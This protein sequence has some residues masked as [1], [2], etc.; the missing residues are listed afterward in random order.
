[1][2]RLDKL[3]NERAEVTQAMDA[4]EAGVSARGGDDLNDE[5]QGRY[6][7]LIARAEA[8]DSDIAPLAEKANKLAAGAAVLAGLPA[9]S[10]PRP[11]TIARAGTQAPRPSAGEWFAAYAAAQGGDAAAELILRA[12]ADQTTGD[13]TGLLPKAIVG[14][15]IKL[16]DSRRPVFSS[17]RPM[18]MPDKGKTFERPTITQRVLVGE[19]VGEKTEAPSRKMTVGSTPVTKKT[20]AGVLDVSQQSIDWSEPALIQIVIQDFFDMYAEVSEGLACD[21]LEIAAATTTPYDDTSIGT[22][23]ASI[24]TGMT[25]GYAAAKRLPD[26]MWLSLDSALTLAGSTNADDTITAISLIKRALADLGFTMNFV[27]GPQLSAGKMILGSSDLIEQ[28]EK[29]NG[30]LQALNVPMLGLDIGYS[31]Y[32]AFFAVAAGFRTLTPA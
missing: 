1:M 24:T 28:Y 11:A 23:L 13:I 14:D 6:D 5:E 7:A 8:L 3:R 12:V 30:I 27:V 21:A 29:Q 26:T 18:P 9:G 10:P 17:F 19:Q 22:V 20:Y 16:A 2:F 31:A 15:L 32:L 4:I 25:A